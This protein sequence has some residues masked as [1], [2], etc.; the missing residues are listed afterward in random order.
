MVATERKAILNLPMNEDCCRFGNIYCPIDTHV[1]IEGESDRYYLHANHVTLEGRH[2]IAAQYPLLPKQFWQVCKESRL[3]VDLTNNG[4]MNKGLIA[5][6][7]DGEVVFEEEGFRVERIEMGEM[8]E[9]E[10]SHYSYMIM[11]YCSPGKCDYVKRLHYK[12]WPDFGGVSPQ[13]LD[14]LVDSINKEED[15][16]LIGSKQSVVIHC[17]AGVGRT[18]TIIVA[19]VLK[20]LILAGIVTPS[21][22]KEKMAEIIL[23]G[24]R[25]RGPMFVQSPD[26]LQALCNWCDYLFE[27]L[28]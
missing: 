23:E 20:P 1:K 17:R 13:D 11:D 10:A 14:H 12:A 7:S 24:R 27:Q 9:L 5:Y 18:G 19:S 26:Q 21:N 15:S 3:I 28:S 16:P 6:A 4:D 25:Q 8:A 2:F 22:L